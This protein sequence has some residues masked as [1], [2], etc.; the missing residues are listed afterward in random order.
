LLGAAIV[1]LFRGGLAQRRP[2]EQVCSPLGCDPEQPD[3]S[4][5]P[6]R[7]RNQRVNP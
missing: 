2:L 7:A 4:D 6:A 1:S 5:P 3:R